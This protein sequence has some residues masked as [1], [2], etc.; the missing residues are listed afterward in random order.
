MRILENR[1]FDALQKSKEKFA[2]DDAV[3]MSII[4]L[5]RIR[6]IAMTFI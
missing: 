6:M 4:A 5:I 2:L 1:L 3:K